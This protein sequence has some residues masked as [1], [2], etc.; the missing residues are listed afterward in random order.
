MRFSGNREKSIGLKSQGQQFYNFLIS[1]ALAEGVFRKSATKVLEDG[2]VISARVAKLAGWDSWSGSAS[3]FTPS[4]STS[5]NNV[6]DTF[7]IL[8]TDLDDDT[9]HY[10]WK[11]GIADPT[12][13]ENFNVDTFRTTSGW[14]EKDGPTNRIVMGGGGE[15]GGKGGSITNPI[16]DRQ[17][18]RIINIGDQVGTDPPLLRIYTYSI[19]G[20]GLINTIIESSTEL[21]SFGTYF[22][23]LGFLEDG[24]T[25]FIYFRD[26]LVG[27][28][29]YIVRYTFDSKY[30]EESSEIIWEGNTGSASYNLYRPSVTPPHMNEPLPDPIT[31]Y[32]RSTSFTAYEVFDYS[33]IYKNTFHAVFK[34]IGALSYDR[35]T[36]Y[37]YKDRPNPLGTEEELILYLVDEERSTNISETGGFNIKTTTSDGPLLTIREYYSTR[38]IIGTETV[39][40]TSAYDRTGVPSHFSFNDNNIVTNNVYT[41]SNQYPFY[42]NEVEDIFLYF[43]NIVTQSKVAEIN[44][45]HGEVDP[46]IISEVYTNNITAQ[47][48]GET[49]GILGESS[50]TLPTK[51]FLAMD[52]IVGTVSYIP[53]FNY[54]NIGPDL[55]LHTESGLSTKRDIY[56]SPDFVIYGDYN[57]FDAEQGYGVHDEKLF[58]S[59]YSIVNPA[60]DGSIIFN[61]TFIESNEGSLNIDG[62]IDGGGTGLVALEFPPYQIIISNTRYTLPNT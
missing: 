35:T 7:H 52:L 44:Y 28:S 18:N 4:S 8:T 49:Q 3:I 27:G 51:D 34:N 15:H 58:M 17:L 26:Q 57:F 40:Q 45:L 33:Y 62:R 23:S 43:N 25:L 1:N 5:T 31:T 38:S 48:V 21:T 42:S 46:E 60:Y 50:Y 6:Y 32:I 54:T 20:L 14:V 36:T 10:L 2:T 19:G 47:A 29:R 59:C 9:I 13:V 39:T 16:Y 41:F 11:D 61:K 53:S 12:P 30:S 22:T 56:W 55:Y 37:T 24:K